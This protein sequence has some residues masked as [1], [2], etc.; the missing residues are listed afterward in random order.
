MG[1]VLK[2]LLSW[3]ITM[4]GRV[5]AAIIVFII[6][7]F[8]IKMVNKLFSRLLTNKK[9][10]PGVISFLRSLINALL[11]MLLFIAVVNKL[12]IETTSFA[13]LLASFGVAIGMAMSGN[14]SN[15]VGGML[16]LMFKPYRVG[17][18]I[19]VNGIMGRVQSIEIFHTILR[20]AA[21]VNIYFSNGEMSS[22]M[23]KNY[24]KETHLRLDLKVSVEYGQDLKLVE[25]TL[26]TMIDEDNR[27]LKT[28]APS[29]VVDE[30]ADSSVNLS[31]RVWV[32]NDDYWDV[33]YDLTRL[34]YER[35]NEAGISFPFPQ[36]TVHQA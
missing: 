25:Q 15:L 3:A 34:T 16:I 22:N 35:F 6:G 11:M 7:R 2:Q 12:G 26:R 5:L 29:I 27:I 9:V 1:D 31:M 21:G 19:E 30:L 4:G 33:K 13:A 17:D 23:I 24:S 8:I 18:L 32:M 36:I 10:D 28:P 14:L 20:T